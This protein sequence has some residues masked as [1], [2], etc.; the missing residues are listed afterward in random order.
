MII[1]SQ[2]VTS[3]LL[4]VRKLNLGYQVITNVDT[5]DQALESTDPSADNVSN[6]VPL[7]PKDYDIFLNLVDFCKKILLTKNTE[8]F[9]PWV[10]FFLLLFC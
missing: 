6:L 1:Y 2:F 4:I 5:E 10:S 3:I 9:V 7:V 8:L